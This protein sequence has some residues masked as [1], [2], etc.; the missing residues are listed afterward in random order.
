MKRYVYLPGVVLL[1]AAF[2]RAAVNVQWDRAGFALAALGAI[3][4]ALAAA[5]NWRDVRAWFDDPA[6]AFAVNTALSVMFLIVILVFANILAWYRPARVDLTASGRNTLSEGTRAIIRKLPREV[7][8]RQFGR[9]RDPIVDQLLD[10]FAGVSRSVRV[11]FVDADHQPRVAREYGVIRNGTVVVS[12]DDK[13][14]KVE[15]PNEQALATALLQVTSAEERTICFVTGHG[16]HGLADQSAKGLSRLVAA[17][18]ASNFKVE[19]VSLLESD[20]PASCA[21]LVLAGPQQELETT[22]LGRLTSFANRGGRLAILVDPGAGAALAEWLRPRGI[23]LG[24]GVIVDTS[25]AGQTVGGGPQTPLALAYG[26]HPITR[27][28]EVAT[29]YDLARPLETLSTPEYGG[30]PV[31]V[32]QTGARSY[33]ET[34]PSVQPVRFD[35]GRDR[36]GPLTLAAATTVKTG[37][38]A[39]DEMRLVVVGDSDFISNALVH[40][41]GNRDF[42]LRTISWLVGEAEATI[43]SVQQRENRRI[44]M[45]ERQRVWLYAV[46]VLLLPL[47]PLV[48]GVVVLIRSRR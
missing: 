34:E 8:L 45:T 38:G 24:D 16:E 28:F 18:E 21:A 2:V 11:E 33:A 13:Y 37:R 39:G 9:T 23:A 1:I 25:G 20:V 30:R 48:A 47:I 12:A 22:E 17:L 35:E 43:V 19:R 46:N 31:A 44:D 7:T 32:A 5:A 15:K 41:Q 14:R 42:F 40:R 3:V 29:L 4:I 10:A 36:P 26:D 6:G 27:G